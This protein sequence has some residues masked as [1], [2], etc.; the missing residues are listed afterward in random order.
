[1]NKLKEI[2][3]DTFERTQKKDARKE[4]SLKTDKTT[5]QQRWV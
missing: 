4:K 5:N 2:K 1:V 3:K